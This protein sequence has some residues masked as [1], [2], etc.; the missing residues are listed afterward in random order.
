MLNRIHKLLL[1]LL[2]GG[3]KTVLST[4]QARALLATVARVISSGAPA[5]GWLRS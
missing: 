4:D 3:A 2:P 1:E 5:G